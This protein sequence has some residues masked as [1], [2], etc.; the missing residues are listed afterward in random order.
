MCYRNMSGVGNTLNSEAGEWCP[1]VGVGISASLMNRGLCRWPCLMLE[2]AQQVTGKHMPQMPWGPEA[3]S[4]PKANWQLW[5]GTVVIHI[6]H[7]EHGWA[8]ETCPASTQLLLGCWHPEPAAI[9]QIPHAALIHSFIY[10]QDVFECALECVCVCV[11]ISKQV[12]KWQQI[13][14]FFLNTIILYFFLFF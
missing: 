3:G 13:R 10:M 11:P 5:A 4:S 8:G 7:K 9:H 6:I 12:C 1:G 14:G 2:L